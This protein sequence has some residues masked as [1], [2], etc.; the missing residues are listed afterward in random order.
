MSN[1]LAVFAYAFSG[2]ACVVFYIMTIVTLCLG[3]HELA[4]WMLTMAVL[5]SIRFNQ[6][7]AV[8]EKE[9]NN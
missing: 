4:R 7:E 3:K 5:Y 8:E 6:F 9:D 2:L 1:P